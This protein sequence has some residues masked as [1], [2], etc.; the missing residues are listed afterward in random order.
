MDRLQVVGLGMAVLDVL[1]R[2]K[3]MPTWEHGTRLSA[4]RFDGG[5]SERLGPAAQLRRHLLR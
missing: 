2:L 3:E 1:I 5:P 4:L